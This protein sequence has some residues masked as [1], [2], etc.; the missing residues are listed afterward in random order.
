MLIYIEVLPKFS[1]FRSG[2]VLSSDKV[3]IVDDFNN[4]MDVNSG[5]L[6]LAFISLLEST[7]VLQKVNKPTHS[8]NHT[9]DLVLTYTIEPG[10]WLLS[11]LHPLRSNYD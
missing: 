4:Y 8:S 6:K 2:L 5:S 10:N 7:G 1:E 11:P 3:V 9:L